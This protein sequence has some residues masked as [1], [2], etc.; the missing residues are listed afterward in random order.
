MN[1]GLATGVTIL[2]GSSDT[3]DNVGYIQIGTNYDVT[4]FAYDSMRHGR[5]WNTDGKNHSPLAPSI[6]L[7]CD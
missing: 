3:P 1:T 4:E 6:V 5:W 7:L 2:H